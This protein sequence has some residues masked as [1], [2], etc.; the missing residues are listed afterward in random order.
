MKI[1]KKWKFTIICLII[2][3]TAFFYQFTINK[4]NKESKNEIVKNRYIEAMELGAKW[5]LNNQNE[6]FIYYQYYP[7]K[8][9]HP[10][11]HHRLRESGALWS[12]ARAG[13]YFNDQ[14]LKDFSKKG[15]SYFENYFVYDEEND[16]IYI[17]IVPSEIKLGYNAFAILTLLEIDHPNKDY[18]LEK[19]ANGIIYQQQENGELKTFFFSDRATGIDYYPGEALLALMSMYEY[20]GDEKYLETVEKAFPFYVEYWKVNPNTAFTPW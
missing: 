19:L 1:I 12:I 2:A 18:L 16:F 17:N 9:E 7:Y 13:N 6:D 5:F 11:K 4:N 10:N 8:N 14:E 15:F 3:I 20:T